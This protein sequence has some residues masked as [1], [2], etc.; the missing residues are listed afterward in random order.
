M[1][2][3]TANDLPAPL[4]ILGMITIAMIIFDV[5]IS[6]TAWNSELSSTE[7]AL[8]LILLVLANISL[9]SIIISS[10]YIF[11]IIANRDI[12]F[13]NFVEGTGKAIVGAGDKFIKFIIQYEDYILLETDKNVEM[14]NQIRMEQYR[15]QVDEYNRKK[16][17][18]DK[19]KDDNKRKSSVPKPPLKK[20]K[21]DIIP[22]D[23]KI[24]PKLPDKPKESLLDD[25]L[26]NRLGLGGI[27]YIGLPG[28]HQI[29]S[30]VFRWNSLRQNPGQGVIESGGGIYFKPHI[31]RLRFVLLQADV[32]YGKLEKAEDKR[33]L[34]LDVDFIISVR[35]K[36]LYK[37]LF[38]P[39]EWLE[40]VWSQIVPAVRRVIRH[41]YD[42]IDEVETDEKG[43]FKTKASDDTN[44]RIGREVWEK[45]SSTKYASGQ[46]DSDESGSEE[47]LTII[48]ALR[49][50]YGIKI[51]DFT[52]LRIDVAG[53][54]KAEFIDMATQV[55]KALQ[56]AKADRI[57]FNVEKE[58]L[59]KVW[60]TIQGF[61]DI[62][63]FILRMES[64]VNASK[65]G[66][67]FVSAPELSEGIK[68]ASNIIT[69][70]K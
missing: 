13:S 69:A 37:A 39:Q 55:I 67:V 68:K 4:T 47:Q 40:Y 54:K 58:R 20:A 56:K 45:L 38:G 9:L 33:M 51:D 30:Y 17:T 34:Q 6:L 65:E 2:K 32:Y 16:T 31:E 53:E 21:W 5:I 25:Y 7:K 22:I 42:W 62:G 61:G 50:F 19:D 15:Q 64:L 12:F 26:Q 49:K 27:H 35:V 60:S 48:E 41:N 59:E 63:E 29:Y 66:T 24:Y 23:K 11:K 46:G 70:T 8:F 1:K 14:Y 10:P 36:N 52:M 43:E 18:I 44:E 57:E 28:L 3:L